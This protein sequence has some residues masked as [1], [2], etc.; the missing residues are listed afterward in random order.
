M[1]NI[2]LSYLLPHE[3][4]ATSFYR[5]K[6]PLADLRKRMGNMSFVTMNEY[7]WATLAPVD[8]MFMQRPFAE[9]HL[10]V[11]E[12][13]KKNRKPL[14]IDFDDALHHIPVWNPCHAEYQ[15][16]QKNIATITAM[17][18]VVSVST[19]HLAFLLKDLNP[20]IKVVPNAWNDTLLP[21]VKPVEEDKHMLISWRGSNTHRGDLATVAENIIKIHQKHPNIFWLFVGENPW[22]TDYMDPKSMKSFPSL[23]AL[24][25]FDLM[26]KSRP[27]IHITPLADCDFNRAKSNISCM[28]SSWAGAVNLCPDFEEWQLP[29]VVNYKDSDDFERKLLD[30]VEHGYPGSSQQK[31]WEYIDENLRLSK[32]NNLRADIVRSLV[33]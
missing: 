21:Y 29:G 20:N 8:V 7:N 13:V 23:D 17:A 19:P 22:F 33:G 28:E 2:T 3:S 5:G 30:M 31:T 32:I 16:H 6:A 25:Y 26:R 11:A 24:E 9:I 12:M 4:D 10:R 15:K 18:D 14:W 27:L 1:S